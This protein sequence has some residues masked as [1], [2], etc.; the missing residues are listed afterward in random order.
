MGYRIIRMQLQNALKAVPRPCIVPTTLSRLSSQGHL[1]SLHPSSRGVNHALLLSR[2]SAS[3][4]QASTGTGNP[5]PPTPRSLEAK[6]NKKFN[7]LEK[8][9]ALSNG[10]G[11]DIVGSIVVG[12]NE[13]LLFFDS[14]FALTFSHT[15]YSRIVLMLPYL[16][17]FPRRASWWDFRAP[18]LRL[19][20]YIPESYVP[21]YIP[22]NFAGFK[23]LS[24]YFQPKDGGAFVKFAYDP[25]ITNPRA[26]ESTVQ[27]H[28]KHAP[29]RPWFSPL[30]P[31][32]AFLVEGVPWIE[33]LDQFPSS[34]LK[35]EFV[36]GPQ[37][38]QESLYNLFRRFGKIKYIIRQSGESK[39]VPKWAIVQFS[40]VRNATA[41]RSCLHRAH[42]VE[43]NRKETTGTDTLLRMSYESPPK[44]HYIRNWI[45]NHPKI[46][47]YQIL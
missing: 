4:R 28:L 24:T 9:Q 35:V 5:R 17:I 29:V 39:E 12:D 36:A 47:A 43:P 34:R 31:V 33:D 7:V 46:G 45:L 19:A 42:F 30:H 32:R 2:L 40:R 8:L 11:P 1:A 21:K 6:P 27:S 44:V 37:L 15:N 41:S 10:N 25:K 38:S 20:S 18:L 26:I 16:D 23:L 3:H 14:A 22:S 13:G